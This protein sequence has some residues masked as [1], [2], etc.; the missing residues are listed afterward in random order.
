M[1][2]T[3]ISQCHTLCKAQQTLTI[4][5]S[6]TGPPSLDLVYSVGRGVVALRILNLCLTAPIMHSTCILTFAILHVASTSPGVS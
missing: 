4:E 6:N 1:V 3:I 5:S 2:G